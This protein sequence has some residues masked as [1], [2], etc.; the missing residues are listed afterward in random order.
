MA[1]GNVTV[2][3]NTVV[4]TFTSSGY[5]T[6]FVNVNNSLRFRSSA[7]A[8]LTRTPTVSSSTLTKIT[9]SAWIKRGKLTS[10]Q[11]IYGGY[12]PTGPT[13]DCVRFNSSDQI[14]FNLVGGSVGYLATT[15]VYRDPAAWYHIFAVVDT[16]QATASERMKL[17]VNG[18]QVPNTASPAPSQNYAMTGWNNAGRIQN[19]GTDT[20]GSSFP[21]DGYMAYVY[22]IDGQALTPNA[23]G[24][25]N[26]YGVWQPVAYAGSYGTNG[27]FL[28]F[29][30]TANT[31]ALGYD[32]S[33]Q[34]NNWTPT[35]I[36]LTAGVSYDSMKDVPTLTSANVANY[37]V[38]NAVNKT[39]NM[40]INYANMYISGVGSGTTSAVTA[41]MFPSNGGKYYFEFVP[42]QTAGPNNVIY[43]GVAPYNFAPTTSDARSSMYAYFQNAGVNSGDTMGITIDRVNNEFKTYINNTYQATTSI[44]ATIDMEIYIGSYQVTGYINFG[45][46]P[47]AYTPP[48]GFVALNTYNL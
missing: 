38:L 11:S 42:E 14:E 29:T 5:L 27:F 7:P 19:L 32:F 48:S 44:P 20:D 8:K 43:I 33:P 18:V 47:F 2:V 45:Q 30:N 22:S 28:P 15:A 35:N 36:S 9:Y 17:W 10:Y 40:T 34:G 25:F 6:P 21:F 16:T 46:Q 37:C 39:S 26:Q 31:T 23:F 12:I 41:T 24:T 4:H 1:G 3:S 13:N